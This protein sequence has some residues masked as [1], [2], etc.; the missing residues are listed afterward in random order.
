MP[1]T[2]K[3][4]RAEAKLRNKQ[5][6]GAE[7]VKSGNQNY[8]LKTFEQRQAMLDNYANGKFERFVHSL[9]EA[10]A[11]QE[12]VA[13]QTEED[14][15]TGYYTRLAP[16]AS[17][18]VAKVFYAFEA[19]LRTWQTI[20]I[21]FLILELGNYWNQGPTT[22]EWYGVITVCFYVVAF[23][24]PSTLALFWDTYNERFIQQRLDEVVEGGVDVQILRREVHSVPVKAVSDS[25]PLRGTTGMGLTS[26]SLDLIDHPGI[27]AYRSRI[28]AIRGEIMSGALPLPRYSLP[29]YRF[30]FLYL[31]TLSAAQIVIETYF[32]LFINANGTALDTY[33]LNRTYRVYLWLWLLVLALD[34][35]ITLSHRLKL[36]VVF[37]S[38]RHA[39]EHFCSELGVQFTDALCCDSYPKIHKFQTLSGLVQMVLSYGVMFGIL[40]HAWVLSAWH[41]TVDTVFTFY[42]FLTLYAIES[43]FCYAIAFFSIIGLMYAMYDG[44]RCGTHHMLY[45]ILWWGGLGSGFIGCYVQLHNSYTNDHDGLL[46]DS[47]LYSFE[48]VLWPALLLNCIAAFYMTWA[49]LR[50]HVHGVIRM[51][52]CPTVYHF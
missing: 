11:Y 17:A 47:D 14:A 7:G 13:R 2:L 25:Q 44:N 10:I 40:I 24:F 12:A 23:L 22:Q 38:T 52:W 30:G 6:A 15:E 20:Y 19:V 5:D 18:N 3:E 35:V 50:K 27:E 48:N 1:K 46:S 16:P 45:K 9:H 39:M 32:Y 37:K 21:I 28:E 26:L 36:A 41:P 4:L 29:Q 34:W 8:A 42:D 33:S 49:N 31:A 51:A 43:A